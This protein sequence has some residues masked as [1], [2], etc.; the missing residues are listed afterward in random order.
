MADSGAGSDIDR[1]G[2]NASPSKAAR[3]SFGGQAGED[4]LW[5][6]IMADVAKRDDHHDSHLL[7]LGNQGSGTRSIIKEINNKYVNARNKSMT[8]D[9]MGSDYSALDFS[10]LYVKDLFDVDMESTTVTVD[11]NLPKMNIWSIHD[12]ERCDLIESVIQPDDLPNT[13]AVIV[14][15]FDEPLEIMNDLRKWLSKLSHSL[16]ALHPNMNFALCDK[17]K[18]K[19]KRYT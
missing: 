8:V 14:L 16:F 13:A 17:M 15:D 7:L 1:S 4:N 18:E 12:Q 2:I 3:G 19:L 10:F 9:K 5:N 6:S 11:D